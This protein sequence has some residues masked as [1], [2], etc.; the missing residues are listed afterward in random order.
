MHSGNGVQ[1]EMDRRAI[2]C[3]DE[4]LADVGL[5]S[6][7]QLCQVLHAYFAWATTRSMAHFHGSAAAVP[8]GLRVPRWSW[9]G[10]VEERRR[11]TLG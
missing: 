9:D 6:D 5:A 7:E 1:E 11:S 3:F 8:D 2:T 4:A 10:L